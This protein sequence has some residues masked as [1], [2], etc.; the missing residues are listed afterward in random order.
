[1]KKDVSRCESQ[2]AER[3]LEAGGWRLA[4]PGSASCLLSPVSCLLFLTT[5]IA[6][7]PT[8]AAMNENIDIVCVDHEATGYATFQ[9]HNQK[10]VSNAHGIFMTHIRSRNEPYTAQ[11]WR[12]LRST[13]RGETFSSLY[14]DTHAT[15]PPV[16]ETDEDGNLYLVRVDFLDGDAYL[17]RFRAEKD[18]RDPEI[19][20]IP[21]GAAGKYA[22]MYDPGRSQL[23]FFSHNNTF[24]IIGPDG[25]VRRS[26]N[27]LQAGE[28]ALLQYPMLS[29]DPDGTLHAAWT[30]QKHNIYLYWDIHHIL[31][32]D[33][34]MTWRNL[35]GSPCTPPI[36]ADDT[37]PTLRITQDDEFEAHTWLS[38]VLVKAGKLHFVYLAQ[39][40]PPRQHYMRYD[41]ATGRRDQHHHP[42]FTGD[43]LQISGL[44]GFFASRAEQPDA[45][46]Y[47]VMNDQGHIACL[48]SYDNGQTWHGH[49]KSTAQ[50][51]PYAIGG[52]REITDDGYIIGAFTDQ[53]IGTQSLDQTTS[54]Y[55]LR[56][57]AENRIQ[58]PESRIQKNGF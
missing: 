27:L 8:L 1:M 38:S 12:L 2:F 6:A 46:L 35:D 48:I 45:P 19:T 11:T 32:P 7:Q 28:N 49:A 36:I 17:Y 41:I 52:C 18:F 4:I 43:T 22:M 42:Q 39:T 55:F 33:G 58:N 23:Y 47:C 57:K 9:S 30:T 44:D 20:K 56:I 16:L 10:M 25:Q 13:D 34:G 40:S 24:H 5:S 31:S 14:E 21:G 54:V 37:G 51:H 26:Y 29:L 50:F 53:S 15:N 3:R